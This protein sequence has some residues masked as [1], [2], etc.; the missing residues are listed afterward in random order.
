MQSWNDCTAS[1]L[2]P[3]FPVRADW[4][5]PALQSWRA[6]TMPFCAWYMRRPIGM[7]SRGGHPRKSITLIRLPSMRRALNNEVKRV[8]STFGVHTEGELHVGKASEVIVRAIGSFEPTLVVAGAR[9]EHEPR[10]APAALGGTAIKLLFRT[11]KPLLLVRGNDAVPYK[12]SMAAVN[13]PTE[14]SRRVVGWASGLVP[15]G[16]CHIVLGYDTPYSE[17]MRFCGIDPLI[18]KDCVAS[19][20]ATARESL[21]TLVGEAAKDS[22]THLHLEKGSPLG[23]LVTEM[24]TFYPQVVVVGRH[25]TEPGQSPAEAFGSLGFRMAYHIPVDVLVVP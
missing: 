17:R 19:A 9:G 2:P 5:W 15:N 8:H 16:D 25:E 13:G 6:S 10:I 22:H 1:W 20:E 12:T 11:E 14:L 7:C 21:E 18:I 24:A 23:I 4:P 3:T